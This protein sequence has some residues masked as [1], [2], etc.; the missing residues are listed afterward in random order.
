MP[1]SPPN[2]LSSLARRLLPVLWVIIGL[3][4]IDGIVVLFRDRWERH[5]PDDY[6][7]RI[8]GCAAD[9]RDFV[10]IGGSP[11]SE[12][13]DPDLIAGVRWGKTVLQNGYAVGL[14]GGTT[15][16]FYY[17]LKHSCPTPPKLVIYGLSCTDMNDSRNEP[18]GAYS[19]LSWRDWFDCVQTR[20]DARGWVTRRFLEGQLRCGWAV[21]R[22]RHGIRMS[23]AATL[24]D[25]FPGSCPEAA[26][27]VRDNL[28]Y[29]NAL[30]DGHGYAPAPWFVNANYAQRKATNAGMAPFD[31]LDKYRT[32]SHLKYLDRL[33][34]LQ[35]DWDMK[36]VLVDMPV[37]KDL[38]TKYPAA[39]AE[40]QDRL[41][42]FVARRKVILLSADRDRLGLNDADFADVIHL[43]GGGAK[44]LSLWLRGQLEHL[45]HAAPTPGAT[46]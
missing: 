13:F 11:V 28:R 41:R 2:K 39:V 40:Y 9:P 20:P 45:P 29:S 1:G 33:A 37:T 14:P 8:Q 35:P 36:L 21:Y 38:E 30:R 44:K 25:H 42:E 46:P 5:S 4:A 15:T 19:I 24:D 18:H 27:E 3:V 23:L 43:N 26:R 31:F 10:I 32:G 34:D 22:Y 17:A 16:D 6:V 7:E 12:G